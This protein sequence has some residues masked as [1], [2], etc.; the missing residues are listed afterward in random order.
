MKQIIGLI[1]VILTF[2]G[3]I[4]Y[5]R[6]TLR[7]KTRPHVYTWFIWSFI[8]AIAF[9]LQINDKGG[10]GAFVTLAAAI[11]CF[12]IFILGLRQGNKNVTQT[13]TIF[14]VLSFI[15][16][17]IWLIAKQ[18]VA[19]IVLLSLIDVLGFL[20]TIRKSWNKPHEETLSSYIL[21]TIRFCLAILALENYTVIT[22]LYPTAWVFAN[23]LFSVM[24]I[25]RRR[26]Q[27]AI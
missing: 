11:V 18:P 10:M 25:I 17:G 27:K 8:S 19:S 24:L 16:T 26:Q 21:N 7:G 4:P 1:A 5:I 9:A 3:Y 13:D 12:A 14:L 15:A 6:D 2:V 23:G 20:P 22:T